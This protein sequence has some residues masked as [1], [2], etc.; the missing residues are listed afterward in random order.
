LDRFDKRRVIAVDSIVRGLVFASVPVTQVLGLG[1]DWL[2]FAVAVLYGLL[3]M[4]PLAGFPSAIPAL[5]GDSNLDAANA[6]E[7]LGYGAAGVV[8]PAVAGLLIPEIGAAN[9]LLVDA[10]SYFIFAASAL[11]IRR[12]LAARTK[13]SEYRSSFP[14]VLRFLATDIPIASTTL[15]FM[16]FNVAEGMLLVTGPWL[17]HEKLGGAAALGV[18]LSG[19]AA[20]QLGGS[21][22]AGTWSARRTLLG[23]GGVE[24]LAS[25]GYASVYFVTIRPLVVVGYAVVGFFSAPMTVWAQSMRMRRIPSNFRGRAFATLR[26]FMQ[27]TLPL[28]AA[29]AAPLLDHGQLSATVGAMVSLGA[30]PALI[31]IVLGFAKSDSTP[32]EVRM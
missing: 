19:L 4:I 20:G 11:S 7:V 9:V 15:A 25:L 22:A 10:A 18:L 14:R 3:K 24:L 5:V 12:S 27:A 16:A 30:V 17:A 29:L 2:I 21:F 13:S 6:L 1:A 31:L 32:L 28:G 8:G 23:I 26:T